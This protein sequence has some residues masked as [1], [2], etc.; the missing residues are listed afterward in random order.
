M[1]QI[2]VGVCVIDSRYRGVIYVVL[3]NL[4]DKSVTFNVG[5]KIA[6]ILFEKISLPVITE[7]LSFNYHTERATDGFGSSGNRFLVCIFSPKKK[8][9]EQDFD[10]CHQLANE[11]F[12]FWV[13]AKKFVNKLFIL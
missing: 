7:L 8:M 12:Y 3:H 13:E 5:D 1:K 2:E 4:S 11:Y 9:I 6:K 10:V